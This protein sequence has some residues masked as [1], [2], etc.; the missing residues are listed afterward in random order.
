MKKGIDHIGVSVVFFCH[1]GK[2]NFLLSK[3]STNS[4]DEH[5]RWDPGGG[6]VNFG[7][8][9]INALKREVEEEYCANILETEFLGFRDVH[10]IDEKKRKTHWIAID[11]KVLINR[12]KVKN[13]EPKKNEEIGWF[14]FETLPSPLH[15]QFPFFIKKYKH[16]LG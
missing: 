9:I 10:R 13:G 7:E 8:P 3:R 14:T 12:R 1:D 6:G 4:R 15:S 16:K 5:G 2:G 11:Y